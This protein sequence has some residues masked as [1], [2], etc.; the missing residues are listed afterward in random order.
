MFNL[1]KWNFCFEK[2]IK[3]MS[4]KYMDILIEN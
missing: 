3:S 4:N 1:S 2:I